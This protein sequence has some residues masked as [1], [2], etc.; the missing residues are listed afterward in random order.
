MPIFS[1]FLDFA[2]GQDCALCGAA[3][4]AELVC[5]PCREALPA[6]RDRECVA[7]FE[8][9]YPI[10]RLVRRFKFAGD[11][12]VGRWL[13]LQLVTRA[14]DSARP[15]LLVAPPLA[16]GRLRE[17]GF[18]QALEIAKVVGREL[19]IE[20]PIAALAKP[21]ETASQPGLARRERFRNLRGAFVAR[22][23]FDG[24]HVAIVD[25]VVTSGATSGSVASLL[26]EAGARQVSVWAIART[27]LP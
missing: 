21:R 5:A 2:F 24:A 10:D 19:D 11:L 25:D 18:N 7:P 6:S 3:G 9:R 22:R 17:R 13:A 1:A 20:T 23:R 4:D 16:A 27:P 12:A 26:L 15:D 14:R 8:Y